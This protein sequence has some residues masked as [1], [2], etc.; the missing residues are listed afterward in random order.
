MKPNEK[1]LLYITHNKT[2]RLKKLEGPRLVIAG[3]SSVTHGLDSKTIQ[4]SLGINVHNQGL[5][6]L[7]GIRYTID[8]IS[9]D[10]RNGDILIL[11]LEWNQFFGRY[12]GGDPGTISSAFFYSPNKI[13][14]KLNFEQFKNVIIG[15]PEYTWRNLEPNTPDITSN[16]NE[17][18]DEEAHWSN[19][20][21][22]YRYI[23]S[24]RMTEKFDEY[25]VEDLSKKIRQLEKRGIKV[26]LF[27]HI[28]TE[29]F[30]K[31]NKD[32]GEKIEREFN[33]RGI[34]FSTPPDF[35]VV[36]VS[37]AS[38]MTSHLNK[39]GVDLDTRRF[40]EICK[41]LGIGCN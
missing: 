37:M 21:P 9:D 15:I 26:Y 24:E 5:I 20:H 8:N 28:T 13:W 17:F 2:E 29:G 40:I 41:N 36:P 4:D 30:Y 35:F 19:K 33:K 1:T 34:V 3:G 38:N 6:G 12:N 10:L 14:N 23:G 27:G 39:T 7:V 16:F 11:P 22:T 18:G 32:L 31:D 25:A